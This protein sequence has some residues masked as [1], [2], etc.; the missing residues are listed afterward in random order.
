MGSRG[1]AHGL[2][3]V[4]PGT[5]YVLG[6]WCRCLTR[7]GGPTP[8]PPFR[9]GG[10]PSEGSKRP[11]TGRENTHLGRV[12]RARRRPLRCD[13]GGD[14]VRAGRQG[15]KRTIHSLTLAGPPSILDPPARQ[16]RPPGKGRQGTGKTGTLSLLVPARLVL[17]GV[18]ALLGAPPRQ[19]RLLFP[20]FS[21]V[22]V[23]WYEGG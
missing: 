1:S 21:R 3:L 2:W 16:D 5:F 4:V 11:S 22:L 13:G 17:A 10:R 6:G 7:G 20:P 14:V 19:P 18:S 15:G 9:S 8:P 23:F 12:P